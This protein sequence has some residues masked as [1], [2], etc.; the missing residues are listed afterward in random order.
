QGASDYVLKFRL[1]RLPLAIERALREKAYRQERKLLEDQLRQ[2]QKMEAVGR[3][4]GG[5]AHDFNNLLTV[6]LGRCELLMQ[7]LQ[8]GSVHRGHAE[9]IQSAISQAASLIQQLL[10]F[11][12]KQAIQFEAVDL[13]EVIKNTRGMLERLIPENIQ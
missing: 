8:E 3:L 2:A 5:I 1:E 13:N 4:A 11:S 6:I 12:R 9:E 10:A 7:L